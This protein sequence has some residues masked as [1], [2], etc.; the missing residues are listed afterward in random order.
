M[1]TLSAQTHGHGIGVYC[2][3]VEG[4]RKQLR[5]TDSIKFII[6]CVHKRNAISLLLV[7]S[8]GVGRLDWKEKQ[9]SAAKDNLVI[10]SGKSF[11]HLCLEQ[12]KEFCFLCLFNVQLKWNSC[13]SKLLWFNQENCASISLFPSPEQPN[14]IL[15]RKCAINSLKY[16][17]KSTN[18]Q[19]KLWF[20]SHNYNAIIIFRL[21]NFDEEKPYQIRIVNKF[22]KID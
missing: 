22:I 21:W 5:R 7:E 19:R 3:G 4:I 2:I 8:I 9:K 15:P 14:N 16:F 20:A 17:F 13:W 12:W 18:D 11:W 6:R 10:Q 1:L